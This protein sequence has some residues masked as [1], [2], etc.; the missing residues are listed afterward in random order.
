MQFPKPPL[1]FYFGKPESRLF[2]CYHEPSLAW[3]RECAIVICQ[4]VGHEYINSHR[5]LRQLASTLTS[6]GYPVLRFDY[7]A[8]GDSAGEA[9]DGT[10]AHWTQDVLTAISEIRSR[11]NLRRICLIGL[12]LGATLAT[13]AA[14]RQDDIESLVLWDPVIKGNIYLEELHLL[15]KEMQ[16]FRPK[17]WRL[18]RPEN[19][20]EVL[21]FPVS[22]LLVSELK[23]LGLLTIGK[24]PVKNV[25]I[26]RSQAVNGENDLKSVF[27]RT[28]AN[29]DCQSRDAAQVW[30]P[31]ANGS[32]LVPRELLQAI[33]S[34]ISSVHS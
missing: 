30:L 16:R 1:P 11:T 8:C 17:V 2:G 32:L 25:L 7:Y 29:V 24:T 27:S 12:R 3:R 31:T 18:N 13:L 26:L 20:M 10:V 5:A 23:N 28:A 21:G 14:A 22:Q 4:P 19:Y 9:L 6:A 15:Q 34:W 33:V